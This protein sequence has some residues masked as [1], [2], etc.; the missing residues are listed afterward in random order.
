MT[1]GPLIVPI[2]PL[3]NQVVNVQLGQQPTTLDIFTRDSGLFIN[4][5]VNDALIIGG[6]IC[7]NA[8]KIV[9]TAYLGFVGDLAFFDTQPSPLAGPLDPVWTGLGTRWPLYYFATPDP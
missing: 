7:L 8:R 3:P 6:V 5:Y 4:V 9:R 1:A 2:Q